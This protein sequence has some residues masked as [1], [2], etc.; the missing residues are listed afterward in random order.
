MLPSWVGRVVV[1]PSS[2]MFSTYPVTGY[3]PFKQKQSM[4]LPRGKMPYNQFPG[5]CCHIV[6]AGLDRADLQRLVLLRQLN[7]GNGNVTVNLCF[8]YPGTVPV[9][10]MKGQPRMGQQESPAAWSKARFINPV[11]SGVCNHVFHH[12]LACVKVPVNPVVE[13]RHTS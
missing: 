12:I 3:H 8:A 4:I 10:I 5:I 11:D 1:T 7:A 9:F 6:R 2:F 13:L